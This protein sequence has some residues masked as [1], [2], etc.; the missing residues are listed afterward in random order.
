M[1]KSVICLI[2]ILVFLCSFS[3]VNAAPPYACTSATNGYIWYDGVN[4]DYLCSADHWDSNQLWHDYTWKDAQSYAGEIISVKD[5]GY[6]V[7]AVIYNRNASFAVPSGTYRC[8]AGQTAC[9]SWVYCDANNDGPNVGG[10]K[11]GNTFADNFWYASHNYRCSRN[12]ANT[13]D[14]MME[15]CGRTSGDYGDCNDNDYW[16]KWGYMSITN[17]INQPSTSKEG[18]LVLRYDE[19]A[20]GY[21]CGRTWED[22]AKFTRASSATYDSLCGDYDC[23]TTY[24]RKNNWGYTEEGCTAEQFMCD[25]ISGHK[26]SLTWGAWDSNCKKDAD[27]SC[28]PQCSKTRSTP[29]T[30]DDDG[31]VYTSCLFGAENC[32]RY[33]QCLLDKSCNY[34]YAKKFMLGNCVITISGGVL[35][36]FPGAPLQCVAGRCGAQCGLDETTGQQELAPSCPAD[37]PEGIVVCG[38]DC[39]W[40]YSGCYCSCL[41]PQNY[42]IGTTF[43]DSC[44]N[45]GICTGTKLPDCSGIECGPA[46]NGCGSC[47]TCSGGKACSNGDCICATT[48][49]S[50]GK[51]CGSWSDG[52]GGILN[53]GIC[54]IGYECNSTGQCILKETNP[55]KF[56]NFS[57][58]DC[59]FKDDAK[60]ECFAKFGTTV[61]ANISHSDN[62]SGIKYQ[63]LTLTKDGCVPGNGT[64]TCNPYLNYS[65]TPYNLSGK[66]ISAIFIPITGQL[67]TNGIFGIFKNDSY[68]KITDAKCIKCDNANGINYNST[69]KWNVTAI[70]DG[71]FKIWAAAYDN[72]YNPNPYFWN[73]TGWKLK[74]DGTSPIVNITY[75]A[76]METM[77]KDF[78]L[79][80]DLTEANIGTCV[81]VTTTNPSPT[82]IDCKE[83]KTTI[84]MG[85]PDS[86]CNKTGL[87]TVMV[88]ATDKAGN[89]GFDSKQYNISPY[90]IGARWSPAAA[91]AGDTALCIA[92]YMGEDTAVKFKVTKEG[93][94]TIKEDTKTLSKGNASVEIQLDIG[95]YK[96]EVN[97][98]GKYPSR[99]Y[100]ELRV[101][102]APDKP[103]ATTLPFFGFANALLVML[104]IFMYYVIKEN[105]KK[106]NKRGISPLIAT[107]L[108]VVIAIALS[109]I[110]FAWVK[111]LV[112]EN[113]EK[114]GAPIETTCQ[115]I[116]FDATIS[117]TADGVMI[118]VNNQGNIP[119]YGINVKMWVG[120][121]SYSIFKKP[122]PQ[123]SVI[124]GGGTGEIEVL[125]DD[126]FLIPIGSIK[127]E[128]TP[129]IMGRGV[130]SGKGKI[131]LC[132]AQM[133]TIDL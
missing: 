44:G 114:M 92:E 106:M 96:C 130:D 22:S 125:N 122:S 112:T 124:A 82:S 81:F 23:D 50:L 51:Q 4:Q 94:G 24:P 3:L 36:C 70:G 100:K 71:D 103:I 113:V 121:K 61:H 129:V 95:K 56:L 10:I 48:C 28:S 84:T 58:Y 109:G 14:S 26:F 37:R 63:D 40:D 38:D 13:W 133:K 5:K 39:E 83:G 57:I 102:E 18:G 34:C 30:C 16:T 6:D 111:S 69:S 85:L 132:K 118:N 104:G 117:R 12:D 76:D 88:V 123:G 75:P 11:L 73:D 45:P 53:C 59:D 32:K 54:I 9:H 98:S 31:E 86:D 80:Y 49:A 15:C 78:E 107:V 17:P 67:N 68:L 77:H 2:F 108:L 72:N 55:P 119:L 62:E 99:D 90:T 42:C 101:L 89:L 46:P 41:N 79:T 115:S 25:F 19:V 87:C 20:S 35:E 110:V 131:H 66:Q 60:K 64:G 105:R 47:G 93:G 126:K 128:L 21:R 97:I 43:A 120:G 65:K 33:D 127:F 27:V 29:Y 7:V 8:A 52:C 74:I 116:A 91:Y 1:K